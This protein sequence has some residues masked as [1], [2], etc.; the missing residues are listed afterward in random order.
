MAAQHQQVPE[1]AAA[2]PV[3][4]AGG[5]PVQGHGDQADVV[6]GEHAGKEPAEGHGVHL[7]V[8]EKRRALLQGRDD[9]LPELARLPGQSLPPVRLQLGGAGLQLLRQLQ[10]DQQARE[11]RGLAL[12]GVRQA[13]AAGKALQ[14]LRRAPP[15]GVDAGETGRALLGHLGAVAVRVL[16]PVPIPVPGAAPELPLINVVGEQVALLRVQAREP[17]AQITDHIVHIPAGAGDVVSQGDEGGQ[18]LLQQLRAPRHEEGDP[19]VP[20]HVFQ[21]GPVV[22]KAPHGHGDVPPAAA[23]LP[24]QLQDPCRRGLALGGDALG[25]AQADAGALARISLAAVAEHLIGKK[26]QGGGLAALLPQLIHP[27]L[28]PQLLGLGGKAAEGGA[29][30]GEDLLLPIGAVH[31]Q[32]DREGYAPAQ[33]RRE[34]RVLLIRKIQKAVHIY[35]VFGA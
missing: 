27:D 26:A 32:T 10:I 9:Q 35:G 12:G 22:L 14:G 18:G 24:H 19:V 21:G 3:K 13:A 1:A 30:Q 25:V 2:H 31:G 20:E 28:L 33:Q 8:A 15:Q 7:H 4:I 6:L 17:G 29:A 34:H 23:V 5:D 16:P 11:G